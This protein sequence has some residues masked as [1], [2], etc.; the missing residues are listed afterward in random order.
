MA[1]GIAKVSE[2]LFSDDRKVRYELLTSNAGARSCDAPVLVEGRYGPKD[3]RYA[4]RRQQ[5][6]GFE[7]SDNPPTF[8][9]AYCAQ[10]V[11]G[12]CFSVRGA[13]F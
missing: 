13:S 10:S 9:D 1:K 2:G 11:E 3:N 5:W 4:Q 7:L 6:R 8:A 12:D